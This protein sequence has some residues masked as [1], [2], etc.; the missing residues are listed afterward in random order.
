VEYVKFQNTDLPDVI[1]LKGIRQDYV[2]KTGKVN[3]IDGL[4]LLIEDK[5]N[6]G[7]FVVILGASGCGKSTLLR[8]ISGLQ[9]PSRK[10]PC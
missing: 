7:Q 6:A 2:T 10:D 4:D 3:V 9:T 1:E 5:P 8:F